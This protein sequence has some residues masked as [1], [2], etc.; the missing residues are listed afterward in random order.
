[1]APW[2]GRTDSG[3]AERVKDLHHGDVVRAGRRKYA[4]YRHTFQ[5]QPAKPL[6]DPAPSV[7]RNGEDPAK[8]ECV[9]PRADACVR[10]PEDVFPILFRGRL[11]GGDCSERV[12]WR[13]IQRKPC[14]IPNAAIQALIRGR[15][16]SANKPRELLA[17]TLIAGAWLFQMYGMRSNSSRTLAVPWII[18]S[19]PV[20]RRHRSS[21]HYPTLEPPTTH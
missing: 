7:G 21:G 19:A 18:L 20:G 8:F 10:L 2:I 4:G 13:V 3:K 5:Q 12:I 15:K 6:A 1:M 16:P 9:V 11:E 14:G 17:L